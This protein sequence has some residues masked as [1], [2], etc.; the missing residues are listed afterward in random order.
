MGDLGQRALRIRP[1]G[2]PAE[3]DLEREPRDEHVDRPVH[4]HPHPPERL[5]DRVSSRLIRNS[6]HERV[7]TRAWPL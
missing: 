5:D 4:N 3:R 1:L 6:G 7:N 2:V